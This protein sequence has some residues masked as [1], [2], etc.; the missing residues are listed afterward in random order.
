[1]AFTEN[2]IIQETEHT[3]SIDKFSDGFLSLEH[4]D[5]LPNSAILGDYP[6]NLSVVVMP[7]YVILF[8]NLS[9]IFPDLICVLVSMNPLIQNVNSKRREIVVT[10]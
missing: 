10:N 4:A 7:H 8:S 5:K 3:V 6:H 2:T 1:M 9:N